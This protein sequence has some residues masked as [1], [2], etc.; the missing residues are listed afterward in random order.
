MP[1]A[2]CFARIHLDPLQVLVLT[3]QPGFGGQKF[4]TDAVQKCSV[5]RAAFPSL[6]IEVD[7]GINTETART[8]VAAGANV[9]VAGSAIFG[10]PD[11]GQVMKDMRQTAATQG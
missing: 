6:L 8:A 11:P 3:V 1:P 9:L 7:G 5:L 4:M 2:E 10:D